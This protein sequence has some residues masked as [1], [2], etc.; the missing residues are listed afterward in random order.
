MQEDVQRVET[1]LGGI[2]DRV[3]RSH[4]C[5]RARGRERGIA[6]E[7]DASADAD[8]QFLR[9][10]IG[11]EQIGRRGGRGRRVHGIR[12]GRRRARIGR[13]DAHE[14]EPHARRRG[15]HRSRASPRAADVRGVVDGLAPS[16]PPRGSPAA[17]PL[18]RYASRAG[19]MGQRPP[20]ARSALVSFLPI[21]SPL[22]YAS[23]IPLTEDVR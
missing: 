20:A 12:R 17:R 15:A 5:E 3:I 7:L 2:G 4:H 18:P 11:H 21:G 23:R 16:R 8:V 13:A 1:D 22:R 9:D 6:R 10:A 14:R 19:G